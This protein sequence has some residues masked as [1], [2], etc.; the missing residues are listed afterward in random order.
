MIA[1]PLSA[2][3]STEDTKVVRKEFFN[4][5]A[6]IPLGRAVIRKD[7]GEVVQQSD[8]TRMAQASNGNWVVLTDDEMAAATTKG[9]AEIV[10]FVPMDEFD[11]YLTENLYQVRVK[12]EKGKINVAAEKALSILFSGMRDRKVGA[13][14]KLAMRGPARYAIL[15]VEGDLF[16]VRSADQVR[17]PLPLSDV[18]VTAA[19]AAL[20]TALIDAIGIDSPVITDETAPIIQAFVDAKAG[21][22][23]APVAPVITSA[24]DDLLAA[25]QA[26]IDAAKAAK[27]A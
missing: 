20:A 6:S 25:F 10:A 8:V 24:P 21:G 26:S 22:A 19:E 15:T 4:G 13:L 11:A 2:Y 1:I 17:Q 23:P 14:V 7:T 12:R 9:V 3:T 27:A 5:D 18:A 16:M